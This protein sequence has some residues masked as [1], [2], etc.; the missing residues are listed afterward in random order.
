MH[1]SKNANQLFLLSGSK[2]FRRFLVLLLALAATSV[3][4]QE[5]VLTAAVVR[6]DQAPA[7]KCVVVRNNSAANL[8]VYTAPTPRHLSR[9]AASKP[10]S[11]NKNTADFPS[12][13]RLEKQS[14]SYQRD[15]FQLVHTKLY[16]DGR[17]GKWMD[18]AAGYGQVCEFESGIAESM[19]ELERP[20]RAYVKA[21]FSF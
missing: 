8:L 9:A 14:G 15:L 17:T 18:V 19:A 10:D 4:K 21:S 7:Q 13:S 6:Y 20:S 1:T 12:V 11:Q 16:A 3:S 5:S 2:N